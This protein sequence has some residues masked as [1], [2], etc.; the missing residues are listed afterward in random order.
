MT[1]KN[2]GH[3]VEVCFS[4]ALFP[5]ITTEKDFVVVVADILRATTSICAAFH[6]G[7]KEII[8]VATLEEAREYKKRGYLVTAEREGKKSSFADFDNSPFEYQSG[9]LK[10]KSLVYFTT[11]GTRA[12]R[13]AGEVNA[14]VIG[15]FSN[16]TV[17]ASWLLRQK[18]NIVILC[19]GWKNTFSLEDTLF[20]GT[21]TSMVISDRGFDFTGDSAVAALTL[22][23]TARGNLIRYVSRAS[24]MSRLQKLGLDDIL[25]Y[26]VKA[27]TAPVVPILKND[28]LL[29]AGPLSNL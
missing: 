10:D 28:R 15:A 9:L 1:G 11:N 2:K 26:A 7:A 18:K 29:N 22:W 6:Y 4:P 25:D 21:L 16:I 13:M 24:H 5:Y 8:P 3:T 27:D 23:Q 20:A 17:L 12:I 14:V 19:A